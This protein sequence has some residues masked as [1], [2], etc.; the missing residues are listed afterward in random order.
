MKHFY[1][2]A[3]LFA[4]CVC[5]STVFCQTAPAPATKPE[6]TK[7]AITPIPDPDHF[8]LKARKDAVIDK[9]ES[10]KSEKPDSDAGAIILVA[11]INEL[12]GYAGISVNIPKSITEKIIKKPDAGDKETRKDILKASIVKLKQDRGAETEDSKIIVLDLQ[13]RALNRIVGCGNTPSTGTAIVRPADSSNEKPKAKATPKPDALKTAL[14]EDNENLRSLIGQC[15]NALEK[16]EKRNDD[17]QSENQQ[18]AKGVEDVVLSKEQIAYYTIC[19]D[20][21]FQGTHPNMTFAKALKKGYSDIGE[22]PKGRNSQQFQQLGFNPKLLRAVIYRL[23]TGEKMQ[24][25]SHEQ[26]MRLG[27]EAIDK[28]RSEIFAEMDAREKRAEER[29]ALISGI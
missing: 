17:L 16:S 28:P 25:I 19:Q 11:F 3:S 22:N 14:E 12:K 7:P 6:E 24:E 29:R 4:L 2:F 5:V 20:Q 26:I 21:H 1:L 10:L 15:R 9:I 13:I 23:F 18:Y 8:D 27:I